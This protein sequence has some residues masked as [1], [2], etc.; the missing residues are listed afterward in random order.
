MSGPNPIPP[1][2]GYNL[3]P[4]DT[5]EKEERDN[6]IR[7]YFTEA[8]FSKLQY[9]ED[10]TLEKIQNGTHEP[11]NRLVE[12]ITRQP[13][14][15]LKNKILEEAKK[16]CFSDFASTYALPSLTLAGFLSAAGYEELVQNVMNGKYDG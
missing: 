6:S 5:E 16:G 9:K 1:A 13:D 8:V 10:E 11:T 3:R 14:H 2:H 4:R 7:D 12:D 15:P